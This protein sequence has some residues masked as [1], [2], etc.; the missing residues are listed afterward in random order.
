MEGLKEKIACDKTLKLIDKTLKT[1]IHDEDNKKTIH[2]RKGTP[3][4]NA[5]S[6]MLAN[7]AL[8][9]LDKYLETLGREFNKGEK[10]RVNPE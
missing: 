3:Q 4:G 7:I 8:D 10:R 2:P 5:M 6:P 1:P 9:K